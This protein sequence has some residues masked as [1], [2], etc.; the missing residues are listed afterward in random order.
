MA[1][2]LEVR[3]LAVHYRGQGRAGTAPIRAVGGASFAVPAGRIVGLV[4]ES[5]CGKTT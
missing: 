3:D 5:G 4:G 1:A 2:I